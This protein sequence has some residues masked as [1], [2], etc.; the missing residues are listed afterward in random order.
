MSS[1]IDRVVAAAALAFCALVYALTYQFDTVPEALMSGLG[2]ELFPRL[3]L[4]VM[5]ILAILML[6]G[7]GVTPTASLPPLPAR[8]WTT[9]AALLAFLGAVH[10]VGMWAS[11]FLVLVG[12]GW[13]WGERRILPL[14]LNA[15]ILCGALYLL[16]VRF[17]GT[18]FPRSLLASLWS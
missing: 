17:L 14:V 13:M 1:S 10:L 8:V 2:P 12:L 7:V 18:S 4:V 6:I 16:F 9:G 3:I 11:S 5:A 15:T